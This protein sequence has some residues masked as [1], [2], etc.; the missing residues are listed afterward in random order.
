[1]TKR[2]KSGSSQYLYVTDTENHTIRRINATTGEVSTVAGTAGTPGS[3]DGVGTE[4]L[5]SKPYS[6]AGDGTGTLFVGEIGGHTVRKVATATAAVT[7]LIGRPGQAGVV[8]G[9]G[10]AGLNS[11]FGLTTASNQELLIVDEG[12]L[13]GWK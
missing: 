7:T 9:P 4:A 10:P 12:A 11:P 6:I 8:L 13:L 5:F 2:A 1:M 3:R